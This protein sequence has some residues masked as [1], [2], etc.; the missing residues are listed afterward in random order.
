M[1]GIPE[2]SIFDSLR[3]HIGRRK[4]P[5]AEA[6]PATGRLAELLRTWPAASC[7]ILL[8]SRSGP[9]LAAGVAKELEV[10]GAS[11]SCCKIEFSNPQHRAYALLERPGS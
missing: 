9:Q 3:S 6:T 5:P 7:R 2:A 11:G 8:P 4:K 10:H 1:Q